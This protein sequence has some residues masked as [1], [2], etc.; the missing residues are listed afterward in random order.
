MGWFLRMALWV[1][2]PPSA[3]RV[4]LVLAVAGLCLTL[5]AIDRVVGWPEWLTPNRV[6]GGR[7]Q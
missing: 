2:N 3:K 5:Y 6:P 4:Y 7:I 1:R